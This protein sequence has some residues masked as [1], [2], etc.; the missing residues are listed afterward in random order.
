M[1]KEL[2]VVALALSIL[3]YNQI[4]SYSENSLADASFGSAAETGFA[5]VVTKEGGRVYPLPKARRIANL[6]SDDPL[7]KGERVVLSEEG[8]VNIEKMAGGKRL[9][10]GM[11]LQINSE[12]AEDLVALPGIGP[13]KAETIV[14]DRKERGPFKSPDDLVR[15]RGI[16]EK[17][18]ERLRPLIQL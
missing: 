2:V 16:G 12:S 14:R 9:L 1:A 3:I 13:K 5:E 4:H 8:F 10:F 17:T 18:L 7:E 15:V 6:V 11:P